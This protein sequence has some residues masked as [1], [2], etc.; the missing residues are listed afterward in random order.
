LSLVGGKAAAKTRRREGGREEVGGWGCDRRGGFVW[1]FG[2][3]GGRGRGGVTG[4]HLGSFCSFGVDGARCRGLARSA[5]PPRRLTVLGGSPG[6]GPA[7]RAWHPRGGGGA[8][9]RSAGIAVGCAQEKRRTL[10]G[11]VV[12][13]HGCRE[14]SGGKPPRV[15]SIMFPPADN[16]TLPDAAER[17]LRNGTSA[18]SYPTRLYTVC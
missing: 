8:G 6:T 1:K 16:S 15:W 5:C 2:T 14:W 12:T 13:N 17:P 11:V 10:A 3:L 9:I 18:P 7:V 4:W